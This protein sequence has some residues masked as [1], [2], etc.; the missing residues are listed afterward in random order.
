MHEENQLSEIES[1]NLAD[2]DITALD[3]RLELTTIIPQYIICDGNCSTNCG[4]DC[5]VHCG[6]NTGCVCHSDS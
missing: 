6:S 2:L 4:V 3:T 5:T 1:F